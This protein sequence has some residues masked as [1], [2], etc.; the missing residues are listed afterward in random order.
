M[1]KKIRNLV[2]KQIKQMEKQG[3]YWNKE[4]KC[5]RD[6]GNLQT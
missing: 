3:L 1:K 2:K 5:N 4:Y 6:Q